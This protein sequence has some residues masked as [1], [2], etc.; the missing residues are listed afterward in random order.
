MDRVAT[1]EE[2]ANVVV[3][4]TSEKAL[5]MTGGWVCFDGRIMAKGA[6]AD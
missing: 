1:P 6:W 3:F 5:I 4:L 2:I